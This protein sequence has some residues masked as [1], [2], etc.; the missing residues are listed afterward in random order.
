MNDASGQVLRTLRERTGLTAREVA[1]RAKVSES[2]LSRV[3][4]GRATPSDAWL[5]F[6]ASVL[7]DALLEQSGGPD[8]PQHPP[9]TKGT[10]PR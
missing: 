6:V 7:S 2:Y 10:H 8:T 9:D 3:E 5:G 4:A 1:R